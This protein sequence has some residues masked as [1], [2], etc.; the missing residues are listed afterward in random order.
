MKKAMIILLLGVLINPSFA[1]F[2]IGMPGAVIK[3]AKKLD[4]KVKKKRRNEGWVLVPGNPG[5]GTSD[6]YVMAFEAKKCKCRGD[7]PGGGS[8]LDQS[9]S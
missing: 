7:L 5:F 3:Q 6:F 4:D 1:G 8:S 9:Q 2:S